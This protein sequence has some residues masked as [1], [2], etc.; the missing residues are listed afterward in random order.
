MGSTRV[1]LGARKYLFVVRSSPAEGY[2]AA[3]RVQILI[4]PPTRRA[5]FWNIQ[6]VCKHILT[7]Y[8]RVHSCVPI[9]RLLK[10]KIIKIQFRFVLD[11]YILVCE[12]ITSIAIKKQVSRKDIFIKICL[13]CFCRESLYVPQIIEK[14]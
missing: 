11:T 7:M 12:L 9:F 2:G 10:T 1:P 4:E 3:G 5:P 6:Y 13:I 8:L 14:F